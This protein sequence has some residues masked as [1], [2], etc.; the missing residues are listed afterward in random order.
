ME[1]YLLIIKTII[2]STLA[3]KNGI[4]Y[5]SENRKELGLFTGMEYRENIESS[6]LISFQKTL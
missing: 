2:D 5:L 4:G 3:L 1:K 6:N